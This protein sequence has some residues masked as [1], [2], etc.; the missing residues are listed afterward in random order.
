[1][2][3]GNNPKANDVNS[4][5]A[6]LADGITYGGFTVAGWCIKLG[7]HAAL[8]LLRKNKYNMDLPADISGNCPLHLVAK[9]GTAP[10]VDIILQSD[11]VHIEGINKRGLTPLM[12][13]AKSDN[14]RVA[15][16]LVSCHANA[17][18][19]LAGKYCAWLL[20]MARRQERDHSKYPNW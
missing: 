6:Q 3:I 10:M 7:N 8:N 13:A 12:E 2:H 16:R 15:K 18:R 11:N 19:G 5:I 20:V 4:T 17:R 1:M 14:F 9:F